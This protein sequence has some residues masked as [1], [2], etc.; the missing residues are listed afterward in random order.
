MRILVALTY[1]RPH[2][3]GL[4]IYAERLARSLVQQG[5][6]VTVLT[7]RF[8]RSLAPY[9]VCDGVE[10]IR[11]N[12]FFRISKGVIM[13]AM[14]M[15]AWRL[16]SRVDVVNLHL[17]QFDAA[18]IGVLARLRRKPVVLTYHCDLVL[19]KGLIHKLAN[20]VSDLVNH[21]SARTAQVIVTNT[22]DY[23]ENSPFL[24]NYLAKVKPIYPP[25]VLPPASLADRQAFRRKAALG[26]DQPFI[27]MVARMATEKGIEFLVQ[28]MP[29][30]LKRYP[31]TKV[32]F[33]GQHE[34]VLGEEQYAQKLYPLIK[35]LGDSW[36]FLGVINPVELTAFFTEA[37]VLALPSIN[38]TESFGMVQVEA[39]MCGTPVVASDL[40]GVRIP[41][42]VTGMGKIVPPADSS[43]LAEAIL[44]V[45]DNPARFTIGAE[46]IAALFSAE[47][48]AREY[49]TIFKELL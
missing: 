43:V 15:W 32:L 28:A 42:E 46:E 14:P 23:A 5:H 7:S 35:G 48:V 25:V 31:Q 49:E 8:D 3:S 21:I 33:V 27:G 18:L 38:A 36:Q 9:E 10:I 13:P 19:P 24:S 41:V 37:N 40:P 22:Q 44:E 1:Y 29:I 26:Q 39:M 11:P 12:V 34:N 30:I 2:Y 4:T 47:A 16:L 6:K 20:Q 17:P 45:L